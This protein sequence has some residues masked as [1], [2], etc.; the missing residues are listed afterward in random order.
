MILSALIYAREWVMTWGVSVT[1]GIITEH[2]VR[3][4]VLF[5]LFVLVTMVCKEY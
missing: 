3:F 2:G 5:F 4:V 1:T